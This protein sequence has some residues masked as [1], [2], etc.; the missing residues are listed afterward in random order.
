[1]SNTATAMIMVPIG[2]SL[3]AAM[4]ERTDGQPQADVGAFGASLMLGI[5]FAATIGGTLIG[6]PPNALF[7]WMLDGLHG[8]AP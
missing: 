4:R 1:V 8:A 5:A 3:I 6:T 2:Q 7:A